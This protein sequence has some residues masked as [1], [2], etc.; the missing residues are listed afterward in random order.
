MSKVSK[1][2]TLGKVSGA[3]LEAT[4]EEEETSSS[5]CMPGTR[6]HG[7]VARASVR[8]RLENTSITAC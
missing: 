5:A 6:E 8:E 1:V 2:T 7:L 4:G 3:L